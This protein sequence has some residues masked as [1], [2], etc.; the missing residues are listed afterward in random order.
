MVAFSHFLPAFPGFSLPH[1]PDIANRRCHAAPLAT[2]H[3]VPAVFIR[4]ADKRILPSRPANQVSESREPAGIWGVLSP[5]K[6]LDSG[7]VVRTASKS[8]KVF[9]EPTTDR[10]STTRAPL[11]K[12]PLR[13]Y[14]RPRR[15]ETARDTYTTRCEP[16]ALRCVQRTAMLSPRQIIE[17]IRR[18]QYGIGLPADPASIPVIANIRSKLD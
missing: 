5:Q 17:D 4:N 3:Q 7:S 10:A 6:P 14:N 12:R 18:N 13:S 11:F 2:H 8:R 1:A 9:Q 16:S 15:R